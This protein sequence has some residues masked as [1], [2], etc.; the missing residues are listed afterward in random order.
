MSPVVAQAAATTPGAGT[1]AA[2]TPRAGATAAPRA[3]T[4]ARRDWGAL[5]GT[6][7]GALGGGAL[8]RGLALLLVLL[9][10]HLSGQGQD[11]R[12]SHTVSQTQDTEPPTAPL[13]LLASH[14]IIETSQETSHIIQ[15]LHDFPI[16]WHHLFGS[17]VETY[18]VNTHFPPVYIV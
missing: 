16:F 12:E 5:W 8:G 14:I 2:A 4:A 6:L 10:G 13:T 11:L 17:S 9:A 1:T 3:D 18:K 7:G 15:Q